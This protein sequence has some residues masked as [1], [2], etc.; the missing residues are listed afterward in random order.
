[1]INNYYQK[2]R[3]FVKAS[4]LGGLAVVLPAGLL[5]IVF[6]WIYELLSQLVEPL[7]RLIVAKSNLQSILVTVLAVS[8]ILIVCFFIGVIVKTKVG[9]FIHS[10]TEKLLGWLI[11]GYRLTTQTFQQLFGERSSIYSGVAL[12][13]PFSTEALMTA[14]ITTEH[15]NGYFSVF[16]PTGPNPTS[17]NIFHLPASAV[18]PIDVPVEEVMKSIIG[19]GAGSEAILNLYNQSIDTGLNKN[20]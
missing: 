17:G 12:V 6:N 5:L 8:A 19:C 20:C 4:L 1:M 3:N 10:K 13:K 18:Y 11:P 2:L 15:P 16:V 9:A 7:T 14:F